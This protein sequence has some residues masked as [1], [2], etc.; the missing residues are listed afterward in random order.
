MSPSQG[1]TDAGTEPWLPFLQ[2]LSA[3]VARRVPRQ[4]AEDVVQD[5]LL[6]LHQGAEKLHQARRAEAWVY[7]IARRA[8]ADYYRKRRP[9]EALPESAEVP[10]DAGPEPG[11]FADFAGDHS[12]H[13]E[14]LSWLRPMA[15][16]LPETYRR[17]LV[18]ADFEGR[19]QREVAEELGISLSGAKSRVQRARAMLADDLRRCCEVS[20]G[21]EGKVVDFRRNDCD[22]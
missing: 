13:E 11:G 22:C 6:R 12:V 20:L 17:A 1:E 21:P 3:F 14:V 15:D 9:A 7:G 4:D 2:G 19:P 16:D 5:V 10:D 8:V 18:M